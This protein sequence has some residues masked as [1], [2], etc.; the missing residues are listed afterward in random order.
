MAIE[1]NP[2]AYDTG[3]IDSRR[4]QMP[5]RRPRPPSTVA[6]I[7][8]ESSGSAPCH[9][10][11][12]AVHATITVE[13]D[14]DSDGPQQSHIPGAV[15]WNS[16]SQLAGGIRRDIAGRDDLRQVGFTFRDLALM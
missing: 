10:L 11:T 8:P 3:S 1:I 4:K 6:G 9:H 2:A 15:G 14:I 5:Q 16:T 7:A 12:S 13:V